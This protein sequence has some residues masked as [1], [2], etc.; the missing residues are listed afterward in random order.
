MKIYVPVNIGWYIATLLLFGPI[1]LIAVVD[2]SWVG[3]FISI[4]MWATVAPAYALVVGLNPHSKFLRDNSP[5]YKRF[6]KSNIDLFNRSAVLVF[7]VAFL[8]FF[9]LPVFKDAVAIAQDKAPLEITSMVPAANQGKFLIG[10]T[11]ELASSPSAESKT[12]YAYYFAPRFIMQGQTYEFLYLPNS[13]M[14]VDARLI[15]E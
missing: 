12:Y 4:I 13:H 15:N 7:A 8:Y 14:I 5:L 9:T 1:L 3:R 10:E 2:P 11:L 6:S